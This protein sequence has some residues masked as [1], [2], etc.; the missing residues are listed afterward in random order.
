MEEINQV[1]TYKGIPEG[2]K[3]MEIG[4]YIKSMPLLVFRVV[5]ILRDDENGDELLLYFLD[6]CNDANL[7]Y[8]AYKK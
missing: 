7:L 8:G 6:L 5:K 2:F 1:G 3:L 4:N